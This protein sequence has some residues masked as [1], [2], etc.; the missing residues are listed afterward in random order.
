MSEKRKIG[1]YTGNRAEYGLQYPIIKAIDAHPDLE[2][3]LFVSGAHLDPSFGKFYYE[4]NSIQNLATGDQYRGENPSMDTI[5]RH[6]VHFVVSFSRSYLS[7]H[8]RTSHTCAGPS[9][10][11]MML[12]HCP[13]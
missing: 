13:A 3:Y 4:K 8:F 12:A 5:A 9:S 2:Y 1:I 6:D 7:T 10:F 11:L